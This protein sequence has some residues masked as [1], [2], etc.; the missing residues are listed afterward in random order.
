MLLEYPLPP[1]CADI[2]CTCRPLRGCYSLTSR[3]TQIFFCNLL[4]F[5]LKGQAIGGFQRRQWFYVTLQQRYV[6]TAQRTRIQYGIRHRW[7]GDVLPRPQSRQSVRVTFTTKVWFDVNG[8][9]PKWSE[10]VSVLHPPP[11]PPV[12]RENPGGCAR[13][14]FSLGNLGHPNLHDV[15]YK[16]FFRYFE[17]FDN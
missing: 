13:I 6:L 15:R 9:L 10:V 16:A 17:I 12:W 2:I 11:L 4:K 8:T 14:I 3:F 1:P 5:K 7:I